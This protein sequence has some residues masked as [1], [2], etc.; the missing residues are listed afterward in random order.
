MTGR[1]RM[2]YTLRGEK[3]DR[4]PLTT[5]PDEA[6]RSIMPDEYRTCDYIEFYKK[7][8]YD[9][10][11]F[12]KY[13]MPD[14]S[15]PVDP[16]TV[17][18]PFG[19][20]ACEEN[21]VWSHTRKLGRSVLVGKHSKGHPVKYPVET[22]EDAAVLLDFYDGAKI[23][24]NE[25]YMESLHAAERAVGEHG[26]FALTLEPSPVQLLI[27]IECGMENFYYLLQ[28]APDLMKRLIDAMYGIRR[29]EYQITAEAPYSLVI[30]VENTSTTMISPSF[31]H[32]YSL[33]HIAAFSEIMHANNKKAVIHMCGHLKNLL[34]E[35][36]A[37]RIDGIH[38][39]TEPTV[40]DCTYETAL[41]VLGEETII[42]GAPN[43]DKFQSPS[44][45]PESV[46]ECVKTVLSDRIRQSNFILSPGI[47]GLP[48]PLWKME[49]VR[50]TVEEF[51]MK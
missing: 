45:T 28:D 39:L 23:Q 9:I 36:K 6:A 15:R 20:S 7:I 16:F 34:H 35:F 31:Y 33:E 51:G 11:M 14:E 49:V 43:V 25:N 42:I 41:D 50:E 27:E 22:P 37:A 24:K 21:G 32:K 10:L 19:S 18:Y 46:R 13:G 2:E 48:T 30:P 4:V 8:G 40:G 26:I 17:T 47:D 12:G 5:I 29:Q 1:E 44:A 38:A 3:T